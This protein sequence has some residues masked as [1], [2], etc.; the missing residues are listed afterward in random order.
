MVEW[1]A[2]SNLLK[3]DTTDDLFSSFSVSL[4]FEYRLLY[5]SSI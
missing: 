4:D 2:N 1:F 5:G 3:V